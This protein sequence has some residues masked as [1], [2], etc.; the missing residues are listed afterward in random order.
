MVIGDGRHGLRQR[1]ARSFLFR[2]QRPTQGL[3]FERRLHL[4][5][6][7]RDGALLGDASGRLLWRELGDFVELLGWVFVAGPETFEVENSEAAELADGDCGF[8]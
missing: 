7:G 1:M 3:V 2:L 8:W 5:E 4:G 6:V